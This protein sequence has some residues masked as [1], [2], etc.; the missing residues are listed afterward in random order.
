MRIKQAVYPPLDTQLEKSTKII[1]KRVETAFG[2]FLWEMV[3]VEEEHPS[4][5]SNGHCI[6]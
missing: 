3:A 4:G 6:G 5:V 2:G 1:R